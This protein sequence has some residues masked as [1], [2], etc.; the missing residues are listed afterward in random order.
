MVSFHINN[1]AGAVVTLPLFFLQKEP[2]NW[3]HVHEPIIV[4]AVFFSGGWFT[5]LAMTRGDIS[6]VTP[7]LSSKIIFVAIASSL[8]VADEMPFIMWIAA[9]V[10]TAGIVLMSA[11]DFKTPKGGRLA[12]PVMMALI[13]AAIYASSDMLVQHWAPGFGGMAFIGVMACSTAA[14]SLLAMILPGRPELHWCPATRWSTL[15][16]SLFGFQAMLTG[17][18]LALFRDAVGVNV[19]YATRGLWILFLV[20]LLGHL[21]GNQERHDSGK[22]FRLR[23]IAACLLLLGVLCAVKG[24]MG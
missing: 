20:G 3:A 2:V 24:R 10:T 23:V 14:L 7:V 5:F 11:T 16:S 12:G 1:W 15:G 9:L 21:F 8:F 4:G 13:S 19:V 18:S 6:L 17:I 22:A